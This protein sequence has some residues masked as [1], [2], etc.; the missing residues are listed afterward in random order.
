MTASMEAYQN[1]F[2]SNPAGDGFVPGFYE[3]PL[4][5]DIASSANYSKSFTWQGASYHNVQLTA[6]SAI[7]EQATFLSNSTLTFSATLDFSASLQSPDQEGT[8][9]YDDQY[10]LVT[11][12]QQHTPLRYVISL[13]GEAGRSAILRQ[14]GGYN[15]YPDQYLSVGK[16]SGVLP[17]PF[18]QDYVNAPNAYDS[19]LV[20]EAWPNGLLG[21]VVGSY[22]GQYPPEAPSDGFSY[23]VQAAFQDMPAYSSLHHLNYF[24]I[25]VDW[26]GVSNTNL[27]KVRGDLDAG[28]FLGTLKRDIP[29]YWS[30]ASVP[31]NATDGGA[32]NQ[33]KIASQFG[34]LQNTVG[35]DDTVVFYVA[36]H[37]GIDATLG[38][39]I[40]IAHNPS[41]ILTGGDV[42]TPVDIKSYL[43]LLPAGT[44]KIVILEA[45]DTAAFGPVLTSLPNVALLTARNA[46][47]GTAGEA[48]VVK[49]GSAPEARYGVGT[50][51][52][53]DAVQDELDKGIFDLR[54][55]QQDLANID[56]GLIGQTLYL[57]GSG[58]STFQ[59]LSPGLFESGGFDGDLI[60]PAIAHDLSSVPLA[61]TVIGT[62]L[63]L[64]WPA[65]AVEFTLQSTADLTTPAA[66]V[67]SPSIRVIVG[68]Q[69][70]VTNTISPGAR[71]YRLKSTY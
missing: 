52:F 22:P 10:F 56:V 15:L 29:S 61:A 30:G 27:N 51:E 41:G 14:G 39:I 1:F 3:A 64:S 37:G 25:G 16:H 49:S 42:L 34:Q 40:A 53:S 26:S 11:L 5:Q 32:T 63:V 71:F 45:C 21:T 28:N 31:L 67:D 59:G 23:S 70:S 48:F 9:I 13:H 44:L 47:G 65:S 69:F 20:L 4:P 58:T 35:P 57:E 33:Q 55:I 54:Q 43:A 50:G 36:S 2:V 6:G 8:F 7:T 38:P 60:G 24:G 62:N 12:H 68:T 18:P 19:A 17:I 66:W 46:S